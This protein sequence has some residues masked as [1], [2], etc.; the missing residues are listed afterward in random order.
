MQPLR[1]AISELGGEL[2][3]VPAADEDS[4]VD[5]ASR[6]DALLVCYAP[7]GARV[8]EVAAPIPFEPPVTSATL[9]SRSG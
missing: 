8:I 6:A 2:E 9:P 7:I 3:L 1:A 4:L 5:A